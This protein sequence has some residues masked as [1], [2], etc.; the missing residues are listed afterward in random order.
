MLLT[1]DQL[2]PKLFQTRLRSILIFGIVC[3]AACFAALAQNSLPKVA[4]ARWPGDKKAAI[5]LTFDDAMNTHL[6]QARPILKKHQLV[7]TFFATTESRSGRIA[8]RNGRC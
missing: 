5:S 7:G 8:S 2:M 6:D 1:M 3:S 4:I